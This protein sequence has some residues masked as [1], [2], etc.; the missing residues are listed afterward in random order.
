M[1]SRVSGGDRPEQ[2]KKERIAKVLARAGVAS[3][4]ECERLIEA[5]RVCVN[6]ARLSHPAVLVDAHDAILI[7]GDPV[8]HAAKTRLWRYHK[9]A[10]LVVT[11]RD[12]QGRPTVFEALRALT[13]RVVSV[14]RL[15]INTEGLLLLTND[16]E[17]ARYLEHPAQGLARTYRVRVHGRVDESIVTR[18]RRGLTVEGVR[19]RPIEA[20]IESRHGANS[21]ITMVLHEGKNREIKRLL[22]HLGVEVTRLIRTHY[23]PFELGSLAR[24]E[25]EE[26]LA[27][28]LQR[29][30]PRY[31]ARN[32]IK[33]P[34][35][36]LE[37]SRPRDERSPPERD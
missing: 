7:D 25:V 3:R 6:G 34:V 21:W 22:Q 9:P 27:A 31:F 12:P 28:R 10:G 11:A 29:L 2:S 4:R 14:G 16:G 30:L 5:G 36:R 32:R 23:G 20:T 18:L 35:R 37:D 13:P 8:A 24:S 33:T 15:D 26:I 1:T 19:Y 17:L